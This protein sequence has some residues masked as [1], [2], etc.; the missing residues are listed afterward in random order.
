MFY[1]EV[2][3]FKVI[4]HGSTL[5]SLAPIRLASDASQR[6][7]VSVPS[8]LSAVMSQRPRVSAPFEGAETS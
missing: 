1:S 8:C 4:R 6:I 7:D 5:Y 3:C 2:I